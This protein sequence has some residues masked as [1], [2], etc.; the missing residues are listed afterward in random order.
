MPYRRADL[1]LPEVL[2]AYRPGRH[3]FAQ[4]LE[5]HAIVPVWREVLADA[6]TPVAAFMRLDPR[7]NGFLLESVEGGERWARYSFIGGDAFGT[8]RAKG[9]VVSLEGQAGSS[10]SA[11]RRSCRAFRHCTGAPSG[12]WGTTACASWSTCRTSRP[13]T[14][15]SRTS[16]CC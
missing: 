16:R 2:T 12:S 1:L 11:A 9:G 7:P 14:W 3:E 15:G 10:R 8:V 13:T 5:R 4:L 6:Q